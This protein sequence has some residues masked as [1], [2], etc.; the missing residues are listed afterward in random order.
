MMYRRRNGALRHKE[1]V[2]RE[3]N[4]LRCVKE[5]MKAL[6][7]EDIVNHDSSNDDILSLCNK[8]LQAITVIYRDS[9]HT[10]HQEVSFLTV[11]IRT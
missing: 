10:E 9:Y 2:H 6:I 1:Y 8:L 7:G 5:T 3:M 11:L 4:G